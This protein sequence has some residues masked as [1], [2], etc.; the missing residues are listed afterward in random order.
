MSVKRNYIWNMGG[1]GGG[2]TDPEAVRYVP[3]TLTDVQQRQARK[4]IG[5]ML[6]GYFSSKRKLANYVYECCY[7][8]LNYDYAEK[9]IGVAP[10]LAG[11]C[12]A[13]RKGNFFGRNLDWIYNNNASFIVYTSPNSGRYGTVC[14]CGNTGELTEEFANSNA[15]SDD[16]VLLPF[17]AMD[18]INDRGLIAEMNV[19]PTEKGQNETVNPTGAI[20]KRICATMLVR[21]ILDNFATVNEAVTYLQTHVQI[22]HSPVMLGMG[23]NLHFLIAD[24]T[25]TKVIEFVDGALVAIDANYITNFHLAGVTPNLDGTVY[26]P[27]T[28]DDTHDAMS[29]NG[30]EEHGAGL[31]RYNLIAAGYGQLSNK[32]SFVTLM[33]SLRYTNSYKAATDPYWFTE[34]VGADLSV[35][36]TPTDFADAVAEAQAAYADRSRDDGKTWQTVHSTV[37]D[38]TNLSLTCYFQEENTAYT[39]EIKRL[40]TNYNLLDNKP[41]ING[42]ELTGN[43]TPQDLMISYDIQPG[44]TEVD[45]LMVPDL[46]SFEMFNIWSHFDRGEHVGIHG[47][48]RAAVVVNSYYGGGA[49]QLVCHIEDCTVVYTYPKNPEELV[50]DVRVI[51]PITPIEWGIVVTPDDMIM[52]DGCDVPELTATQITNLY[53]AMVAG[54]NCIITNDIGDQQFTVAFGQALHYGPSIMIQYFSEAI[55]EYIITEDDEIEIEVHKFAVTPE[56]IYEVFNVTYGVTTAAEITAASAAKKV[57]VMYYNNTWW[58]Y[59]GVAAGYHIFTQQNGNASNTVR[60]DVANDTWDLLSATLEDTANKVTSITSSSTNAQY[61]SAK[62][63][64]DAIENAKADHE[65]TNVTIGTDTIDITIT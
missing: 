23:Y 30:I 52:V 36:S 33:Q 8:D 41:K 31:E 11:F 19:V 61:P 64:Y 21:F 59:Y 65:I 50:V 18:G 15:F 45:G 14:I 63:V 2:G 51:R 25:S 28:M 20:E 4:N 22:F 27:A 58:K 35:V 39:A 32:N 12:S 34:F 53:N 3:Q 44:W 9:H 43:K 7:D 13:V 57:V 54:K 24:S 10:V 62:A 26:T 6:P 17:M 29:T 46:E 16:Y 5:A 38:M 48:D 55:V 60:C 47:N 42:I 1:A 37:Y 49:T 40:N 56:P